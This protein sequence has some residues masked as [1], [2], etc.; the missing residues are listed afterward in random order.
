MLY[1]VYPV[2]PQLK[3]LIRYYWSYDSNRTDL[4]RLHIKSFADRFPRLVFQNIIDYDPIVSKKFGKMSKCYLSGVDSTFS[5]ATWNSSFSHFGVSFFPHA[6]SAFFNIDASEL[7]NLNVDLLDIEKSR[8]ADQLE[9]AKNHLERID[10]INKYFFD[11]LSIIKLDYIIS[12][13]VFNNKIKSSNNVSS[14]LKMYNLSER[15][16]QRKFKH[17]VGISVKKYQRLIRFEKALNLLTKKD[18]GDLTTVGYQIGYF[19]QSHFINDFTEFAGISPYQFI[20]GKNLGS[21][22]SSFIYKA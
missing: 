15:Q 5:H 8:I 2:P 17:S 9:S 10:A 6:L 21:E 20:K 7:N 11:K 22:S 14:I 1:T 19:D 4:G 16:V 12:D 13:I 3:E 18:F